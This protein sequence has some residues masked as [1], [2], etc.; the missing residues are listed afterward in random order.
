M[1]AAFHNLLIVEDNPFIGRN[2][3]DAAKQIDSIRD[4][5]LTKSLHEAISIFNKTNFDVIILDL[6]LPDGN[7]IE[8]LRM[9]QKDK[10]DTKVFVFS[11]S[12]ELRKT[13]F[14]YGAFAFFDKAKD[15]DELVEA[16]KIA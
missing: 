15:F 6:K 7:G 4:I 11:I 3:F 14:K 13:C 2:I 12:T 9:L 10:K 8:L 1:K 16:I 5:C